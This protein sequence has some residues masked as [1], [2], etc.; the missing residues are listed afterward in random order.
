M[1]RSAFGLRAIDVMMIISTAKF[2]TSH[3]PFFLANS[4]PWAEKTRSSFFFHSQISNR[5]ACVFILTADS[6]VLSPFS[7]TEELSPWRESKLQDACRTTQEPNVCA[8]LPTQASRS[9]RLSSAQTCERTRDFFAPSFFAS[10]CFIQSEQLLRTLSLSLV[11]CLAVCFDF[12]F[13]VFF[14]GCAREMKSVSWE[15]S[16]SHLAETRKAKTRKKP[17]NVWFARSVCTYAA[18]LWNSRL[19]RVSLFSKARCCAHIIFR[20]WLPSNQLN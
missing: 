9:F 10:Q 18:S 12:A 6:S 20:S 19:V 2:W 5:F 1:A 15:K 3:F 4:F 14:P 17:A 13:F 11:L 8:L 16:T 7:H